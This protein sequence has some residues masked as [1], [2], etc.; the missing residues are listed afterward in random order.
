VIKESVNKILR[1]GW[2]GNYANSARNSFC[3]KNTQ[4]K[5]KEEQMNNDWDEMEKDYKC[6]DNLNRSRLN[7]LYNMRNS[8]SNPKDRFGRNAIRNGAFD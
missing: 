7:D 1:E 2:Y 8:N 3:A 4:P 5:T 6:D